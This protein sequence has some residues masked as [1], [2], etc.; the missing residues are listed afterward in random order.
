MFHKSILKPFSNVVDIFSIVSKKKTKIKCSLSHVDLKNFHSILWVGL[1]WA[2]LFVK[3]LNHTTRADRYLPLG[4]IEKN[5]WRFVWK[6]SVFEEIVLLSKNWFMLFSLWL[7]FKLQ[8]L[9]LHFFYP[10]YSKI[11]YDWA[12]KT[13]WRLIDFMSFI[14]SWAGIGF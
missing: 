9:Y 12:W 4:I 14:S 6:I 1:L 10:L 8:F 11:F 3:W 2:K 7:S 13:Y 5:E